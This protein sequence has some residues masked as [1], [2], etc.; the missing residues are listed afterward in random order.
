MNDLER[1]KLLQD[2]AIVK[3]NLPGLGPSS[4]IIRRR[5]FFGRGSEAP[6]LIFRVD[7]ASIY[8]GGLI[9]LCSAS[10]I[11]Y[12]AAVARGRTKGNWEP[13][14]FIERNFLCSV[15]NVKSGRWWVVLTSSFTHFQ[16]WHLILNMSALWGVG[17]QFIWMFGTPAFVG[18]WLVSALTGSLGSLFWERYKNSGSV[19]MIGGSIG[20]STAIFGIM[21]AEG[22]FMPSSLLRIPMIPGVFQAW[23]YCAFW[24]G[25]SVCCLF[26]GSLPMIGH[27][28]HLGG[29]AGGVAAYFL[30]LRRLSPR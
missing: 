24:F 23:K 11:A 28:G 20:S 25:A 10:T 6:N 3:A 16:P 13:L 29:M 5:Q 4:R 30:F 8:V 15:N 26:S 1:S 12:W 19:P 17:R 18:T 9:G 2:V 14:K 21:F 27:A 22:S 7:R